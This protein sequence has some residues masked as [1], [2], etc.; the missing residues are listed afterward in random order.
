[1]VKDWLERKAFKKGIEQKCGT[2][3]FV[4]GEGKDNRKSTA[5]IG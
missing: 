3:S 4:V 5:R 2:V 1:M